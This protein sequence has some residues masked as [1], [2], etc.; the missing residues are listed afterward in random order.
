[1]DGTNNTAN[2]AAN[3]NNNEIYNS[4]SYNEIYNNATITNINNID[5][6]NE[7]DNDFDEDFNNDFIHDLLHEIEINHP[8]SFRILGILVLEDVIDT[9]QEETDDPIT[10]SI[11]VKIFI[12]R[13]EDDNFDGDFFNFDNDYDKYLRR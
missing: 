2:N 7:I 3:N 6:D 12:H 5:N 10:I 9:I 13:F 11:R 8:E 1:M 4:D